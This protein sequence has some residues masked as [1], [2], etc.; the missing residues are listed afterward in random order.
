MGEENHNL[1]YMSLLPPNLARPPFEREK[2]QIWYSSFLM[3]YYNRLHPE[4]APASSWID[5]S[6]KNSYLQPDQWL[7]HI[8]CHQ[9]DQ[10]PPKAPPPM[11]PPAKLWRWGWILGEGNWSSL[12][13]QLCPRPSRPPHPLDCNSRREEEKQGTELRWERK[14]SCLLISIWEE[15]LLKKIIHPLQI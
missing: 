15:N 7:A 11:A 9:P 13:D 6:P 1:K 4:R 2:R 3:P 5:D 12:A 14:I 8:H 10:A